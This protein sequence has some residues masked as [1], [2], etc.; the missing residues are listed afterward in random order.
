MRV[1]PRGKPQ[2]RGGFHVAARQWATRKAEGES[3][4]AR[5]RFSGTYRD[6]E[7]KLIFWG[8]EETPIQR[9]QRERREAEQRQA[10]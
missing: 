6:A 2:G 3:E 10:P 9:L 7:G 8:Q 1:D 5:L 4:V